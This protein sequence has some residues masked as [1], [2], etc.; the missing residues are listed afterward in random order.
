MG[1]GQAQGTEEHAAV[2]SMTAPIVPM[3]RFRRQMLTWPEADRVVVGLTMG[4]GIL[5]QRERDSTSSGCRKDECAS[6]TTLSALTSLYTTPPPAVPSA[7]P[8]TGVEVAQVLYT[9]E[10]LPTVS[11][12]DV[13]RCILSLNRKESAVC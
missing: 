6:A 8:S 9:W 13:I 7:S 10:R 5:T 3:Q 11:R 4:D 1:E 2:N 12:N